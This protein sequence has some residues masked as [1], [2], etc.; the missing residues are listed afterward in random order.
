MKSLYWVIRYFYAKKHCDFLHVS[1]SEYKPLKTPILLKLLH[2]K[3]LEVRY[4][5]SNRYS[6]TGVRWLIV[7]KDRNIEIPSKILSVRI[8]GDD[9]NSKIPMVVWEQNV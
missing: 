5:S 4:R 8:S 3:L 2:F 1:I 7:G 6:F 9:T